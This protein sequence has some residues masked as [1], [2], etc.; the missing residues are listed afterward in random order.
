MNGVDASSVYNREIF[1][2]TKGVGTLQARMIKM[3]FEPQVV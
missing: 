1:D 3:N 2:L